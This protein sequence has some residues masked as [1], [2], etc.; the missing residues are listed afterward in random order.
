MSAGCGSHRPDS[1]RHSPCSRCRAR[2]GRSGGRPRW[3]GSGTGR[4]AGRSDSRQAP[5]SWRRR[6]PVG[7]RRTLRT[8]THRYARCGWA[9]WTL[10]WQPELTPAVLQQRVT[11]VTEPAVL[12]GRAIAVVQAA[13]TLAGSGITRL[14]V[15]HVDVPVA[16]TRLAPPT[17]LARVSV[18][19][20]CALVAASACREQVRHGRKTPELLDMRW[21]HFLFYL[22]TRRCT[23]TR[24]AG[25]RR[26]GN[27]LLQTAAG[28]RGRQDTCRDG[29]GLL[30]PAPGRH[31]NRPD[32]CTGG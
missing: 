7:D 17:C 19:T 8:Q 20:R 12:A 14:R 31:S 26:H 11:I 23:R 9:C 29:S 25:R 15:Q 32:T 5:G 22:C 27:K 16:L 4:R 3:G 13:H 18:V 1:R 21:Y 30:T 2:S 24:P 28:C 6:F 10:P